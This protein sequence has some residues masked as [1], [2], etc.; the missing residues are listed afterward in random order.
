[1]TIANCRLQFLFQHGTLPYT[2]DWLSFLLIVFENWSIHV[3]EQ[4]QHTFSGRGCWLE[5]FLGR[6]GCVSPFRGL[7]FGFWFIIMNPGFVPHDNVCK[8][9]FTLSMVRCQ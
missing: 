2:V 4:C 3:P 1:M 8:K 7:S 5:L 6:R 9:L